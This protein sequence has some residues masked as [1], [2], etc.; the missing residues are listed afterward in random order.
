MPSHTGTADTVEDRRR[1]FIVR[2]NWKHAL[3]TAAALATLVLAA[4]AKYRP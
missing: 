3:Y 4:G 2:N 1:R